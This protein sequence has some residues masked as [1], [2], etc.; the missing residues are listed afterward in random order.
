MI[1]LACAVLGLTA[2]FLAFASLAGAQNENPDLKK[3]KIKVGSV[4]VLPPKADV[5]KQESSQPTRRWKRPSK[6][7][8]RCPPAL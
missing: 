4:L 3:G 8:A 6:S 5:Q 1:R 7:R 2:V